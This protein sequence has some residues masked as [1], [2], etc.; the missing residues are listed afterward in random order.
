MDSRDV[1]IL[2]CTL[3]LGNAG[4]NVVV[5]LTEKSAHLI[6]ECMSIARVPCAEQR[7]IE[8]V[9]VF[10]FQCHVGIDGGTVSQQLA[11]DGQSYAML[12]GYFDG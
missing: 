10:R 9:A 8:V 3:F 12:V 2:H 7:G 5:Y 1:G 11:G 4:L 6:I